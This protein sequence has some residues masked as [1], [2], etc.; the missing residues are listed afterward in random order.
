MVSRS[1][2]IEE[3]VRRIIPLYDD[4]SVRV[5]ASTPKEFSWWQEAGQIVWG[6]MTGAIRSE[7]AR[8]VKEKVDG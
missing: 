1:Q 2:A 8:I 3:A 4:Y 6:G 5:Y 7:F